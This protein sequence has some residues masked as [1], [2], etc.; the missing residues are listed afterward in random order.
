MTA[1]KFNDEKICMADPEWCTTC[2]L[3]AILTNEKEIM[4][5]SEEELA[6]IEYSLSY[7]QYLKLSHDAK[8]RID[9]VILE[10]GAHL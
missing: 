10:D 1:C 9:L 8:K 3:N 7:E 2:S 6:D 5:A 4:C